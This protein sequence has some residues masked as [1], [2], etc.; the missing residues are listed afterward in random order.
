MKTLERWVASAA[1][2]LLFG[3]AT[4]QTCRFDAQPTD[5]EVGERLLAQLRLKPCLGFEK[6]EDPLARGVHKRLGSNDQPGG[7]LALTDALGLLLEHARARAATGP[8]SDEWRRL[9]REIEV[10][11]DGLPDPA[12]ASPEDYIAAADKR[13]SPRWSAFTGGASNTIVLDGR[14]VQPVA[15]AACDAAGACGELLERM[16]MIRSINLMTALQD[17]LQRPALVAQLA[18]A[19]TELARW[20]AYRKDSQHQYF[21][22]LWLNSRVM[23]KDKDLCPRDES[24][25]MLGFCRVP[26]SQ[27]ILLHPD[28]GLRWSRRASNTSELEPA[29]LVDIVGQHFLT[30]Q[31]ERSARISR[32]W[33]YSLAATYSQ[34]DGKARWAFGPRLHYNGYNLALTRSPGGHWG[35]V[36]NLN[37]ANRYFE[38]KADYADPLKKLEKP[39]FLDLLAR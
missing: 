26:T 31:D 37:L 23:A 32:Q 10:V 20:Q 25:G 16:R 29:L 17:H 38:R 35:V 9:A 2:L 24:G 8:L 28:G 14:T 13:L 36:I 15:K 34:V 19:Q 5:P 18:V 7:A 22:E 3:A 30:W 11:L 21:W 12:I 1:L 4:A 27:W 6:D 39:G 33:G